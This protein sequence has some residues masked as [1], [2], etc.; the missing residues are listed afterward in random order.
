MS[1]TVQPWAWHT[2]CADCVWGGMYSDEADAESAADRH[3][4]EYHEEPGDSEP[5]GTDS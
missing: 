2:W 5:G 3:N 1:A 4:R